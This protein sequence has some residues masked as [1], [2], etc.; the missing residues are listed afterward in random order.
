MRSRRAHASAQP[1][2]SF[3]PSPP[4]LS[5][6]S[7]RCALTRW[8]CWRRPQE[9]KPDSQ[10]KNQPNPE[11]FR[12][13]ID[14]TKL[15]GCEIAPSGKELVLSAELEDNK[16]REW[17]L[18]VPSSGKDQD[19]VGRWYQRMNAIIQSSS[20]RKLSDRKKSGGRMSQVR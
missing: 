16:T 13:N 3:S 8:W 10:G 17:W 19:D 1:S 14:L 2:L 15:S 20:G 11:T 5:S 6:T 12:G 4:A 9:A 7:D 18:R